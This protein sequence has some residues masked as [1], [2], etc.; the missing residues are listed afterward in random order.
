MQFRCT[1]ETSISPDQGSFVSYKVVIR[2][3]TT[4]EFSEDALH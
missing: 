1:C 4:I 2:F 3:I